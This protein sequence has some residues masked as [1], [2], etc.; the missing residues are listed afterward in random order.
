M[1]QKKPKKKTG[2]KVAAAP[3]AVKKQEVKKV[4]NPLFEKRPRNFGIGQDIQ[5]KRDLSRFVRWPKYVRIQRQKAVLQK[6]LKVPPPINQFTQT[7]DK[8]TATQLFKI[9]EKYRPETAAAKKQR[10]KARAEQKVAKKEDTPTKKPN[11]LAQGA[12]SVTRLVEQKKAQIVAI[13]HD[14]EPVELVLFL[15]AL[16]RKMGVPYCI[17]KGKARLGML[18]HRKT[19]A[20]VALTNVDSGDRTALTKV[21]E[22]VKTNYNDRYE[23]IKRHWGG[24]LLGSK[25]AARIAKLEKAKAAADAI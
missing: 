13:A 4:V 23:E 24:G 19:C 5:P 18:V 3:L 25:S 10:L 15:P 1:V 12:N 16:C 9:L 20:A 2:K 11:T 7:L 21:L 6:R 22:A 17:V 14:V 8:Q